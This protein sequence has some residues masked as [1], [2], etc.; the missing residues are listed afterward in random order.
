MAWFNKKK[1]ET[2][3]TGIFKKSNDIGKSVAD[4]AQEAADSKERS[5]Q[6]IHLSGRKQEDK[7]GVGNCF[8]VIGSPEGL[9][10]MLFAAGMKEVHMA[11]ILMSVGEKLS[12]ASAENAAFKEVILADN[13]PCDC[14]AC[15]PQP[16]KV[17][18]ITLNTEVFNGLD[19]EKIENMSEADMDEFV[20][21]AID[22]AKPN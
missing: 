10:E 7:N 22:S 1:E 13:E 19:I 5:L 17:G 6:M 4:L 8:A 16:Q 12:N 18:K 20:K 21:K 2:V 3:D 11:R 9:C 15:N 14:P